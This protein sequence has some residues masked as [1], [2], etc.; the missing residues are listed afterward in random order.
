MELG[1]GGE[2]VEELLRRAQGDVRLG[3]PG[4]HYLGP[5]ISCWHQVVEEFLERE[6]RRETKVR[7]QLLPTDVQH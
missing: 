6:K 7:L 1:D 3:C 2:G 4:L 5:F